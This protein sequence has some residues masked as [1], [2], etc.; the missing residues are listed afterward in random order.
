MDAEDCIDAIISSRSD[1]GQPSQLAMLATTMHDGSN[2]K[3]LRTY[4][5]LV[6]HVGKLFVCAGFVFGKLMQFSF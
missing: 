1:E 6:V 5:F 4:V 3:H 2:N